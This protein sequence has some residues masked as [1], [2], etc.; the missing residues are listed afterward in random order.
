[1]LRGAVLTRP[2]SPI[3]LASPARVDRVGRGSALHLGHGIWQIRC[4]YQEEPE[5]LGGPGSLSN[6]GH[7]RTRGDSRAEEPETEG[8]SYPR[9]SRSEG[10][11]QGPRGGTHDGQAHRHHPTSLGPQ[12]IRP[13]HPQTRLGS[14]LCPV[15]SKYEAW[16]FDGRGTHGGRFKRH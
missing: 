13:C 8:N 5:V 4:L 2:A 6:K 3:Q 9:R 7:H 10:Q 11:T 12:L 14:C 16:S 1:M 15:G